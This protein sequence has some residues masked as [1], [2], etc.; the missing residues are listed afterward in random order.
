MTSDGQ[1]LY[2]ADQRNHRLRRV[3]SDVSTLA[4][5]GTMGIDDGPVASALLANPGG[6]AVFNGVIYFSSPLDGRIRRLQG[7]TIDTLAGGPP[8]PL[9]DGCATQVS[10][11]APMGL[12][13]DADAGTVYFADTLHHAIR[14]LAANGAVVTLAGGIPGARDGTFDDARFNAPRGVHLTPDGKLLIAD[15]GNGTVRLMDLSARKVTTLFGS[16]HPTGFSVAGCGQDLSNPPSNATLCAPKRAVPGNS[17]EVYFTDS[18]EP[19]QGVIARFDGSSLT[20]LTSNWFF[21][22][23]LFIGAGPSFIVADGASSEIQQ[24][25][26]T[27]GTQYTKLLSTDDCDKHGHWEYDCGAADALFV[28]DDLYAL[29]E[30]GSVLRHL[31]KGSTVSDVVA[32]AS[33]VPGAA[34]GK[35]DTLLDSPSAL[36]AGPDGALYVADTGNGRIR[37]VKP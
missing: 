12:D 13:V 6:I 25:P 24:Y 36:A 28:G 37:R 29:Y 11:A 26:A 21:P 2:V 17:G 1:A 32:G 8:A 9:M 30:G 3:A 5:N 31:G 27:G 10:L 14:A 23:G 34:D 16:A 7:G 19:G 22:R 35:F 18:S 15:T 4:G 20:A 33:F